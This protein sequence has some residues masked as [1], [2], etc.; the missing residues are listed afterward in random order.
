MA[1]TMIRLLASFL[2]ALALF[3]SPL[4][5]EIGGG[6]AMAHTTMAQMDGGCASTHHSSP[7]DQKSDVQMSCAIAC[8]AIPA[9]PAGLAVQ[10][11]APRTVNAS[12]PAQVLS[13]IWPE[14]ETPPP[15]IAPEI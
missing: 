2:A 15:R 6:A 7:D 3:F 11:T 10:T 14:G 9:A 1:D 13:G 4:A 8:A 5:M 12:L